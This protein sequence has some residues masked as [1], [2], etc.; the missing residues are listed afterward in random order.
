MQGSQKKVLLKEA[1]A[2]H[3]PP[4]IKRRGKMGFGVPLP[5]WFRNELKPLLHEVLFSPTARQRGWFDSAKLEVLVEE[6]TS[7]RF[8]HSN[9]LWAL[10]MLELWARKYLDGR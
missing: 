2:E 1:F 9:R 5:Y 7:G 8:E 10:V 3:L 4:A 6:H